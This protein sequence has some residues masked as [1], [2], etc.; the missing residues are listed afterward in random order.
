M[1]AIPELNVTLRGG[2]E[3]YYDYYSYI[4]YTYGE[5]VYYPNS[6]SFIGRGPENPV[7]LQSILLGTLT[8]GFSMGGASGLPHHVKVVSDETS[9]VCGSKR[10][11]ITF[12]VV[13]SNGRNAGTVTVKESFFDQQSGTPRPSVYNTCRDETISPSG[14]APTDLGTNGKFGDQLWVGCPSVTGDC[15]AS[16][17]ISRWSWCPRGRPE[18]ALTT[19]T[20]HARRNFALINGL[21]SYDPG[22]HLY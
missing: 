15:G 12:Q 20:Y 16:E 21:A 1:E 19:N 18:V 7:N 17:I 9:D 4:E 6:Y 3:Y 8:S 5:P 13:D 22:T 10:R 14:C 2:N 11:R